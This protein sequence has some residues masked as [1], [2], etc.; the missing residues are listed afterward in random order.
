MIDLDFLKQKANTIRLNSIKAVYLA[1]SGHPGGALSAIDILTVLYFYKMNIDP[2]RPDLPERDRFVLSKGHATPG[3]Y[4]TLAERGYFP[5]EE[6]KTFRKLGSSLQGHPD[7]QRLPGVEMST[8]SLGQGFSASVGMALAARLDKRPTHIYTM[9]GDGEMQEGLVW[10]AAMAA[11]HYNLGNLTVI[12]DWNGL[13]IDGTNDEV[14]RITPVEEKFKSFGW[15]TELIDGHDM[16]AIVAALDR[17]TAAENTPCAIIA[18]T[19][20]GKGVSY[21]ENNYA[22]H[23]KAP[24][25]TLAR[26]AVKDLGGRWDE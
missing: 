17:A 14:M 22:W 15:Q 26:Q 23:G 2:K 10:E 25:E 3:L 19:V 21:M 18:K 11:A 13:Q 4:A 20:K 8:G 1:G 16:A 7:M 24:D 6:L 12:V 5:K 9:I